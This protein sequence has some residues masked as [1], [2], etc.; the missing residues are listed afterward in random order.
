MGSAV[1]KSNTHYI[2]NNWNKLKCSPI[3]PLLQLLKIAPGNAKETA[4]ECR[5]NSFSSQFNSSMSDNLKTQNKLSGGLNIVHGTLDKF[6][7]VIAT[8][9]QEAF[10]DLSR[11]A[12]LIFSIYVK[13]GNILYVIT[14]QLVNLLN[15]FKASL[16]TSAAIAKLLVAFMNLIRIPIN[17]IYDFYLVIV[18]FIAPIISL[19]MIFG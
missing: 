6:R 18:G 10:K 17:V 16:D 12:T 4:E 9:Q 8:M 3:G 13:I 15:L 1:S 2:N 5:S 19:S 7:K 14:Q 11:V